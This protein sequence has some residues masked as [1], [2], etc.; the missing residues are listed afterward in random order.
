MVDPAFKNSYYRNI[1]AIFNLCLPHLVTVARLL[2]G[3]TLKRVPHIH[4][5]R[6]LL[7]KKCCRV[8]R[9][10]KELHW[11]AKGIVVYRLPSCYTL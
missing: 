3:R 5:S 11:T 4:L 2:T 10:Y 6:D 7:E 8:G 1:L 9:F